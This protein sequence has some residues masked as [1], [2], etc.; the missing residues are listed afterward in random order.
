M[1]SAG[2]GRLQ[3]RSLQKH[4]ED[5]RP[6]RLGDTDDGRDHETFG[7]RIASDVMPYTLNP[8][9]HRG[10]TSMDTVFYFSLGVLFLSLQS[11]GYFYLF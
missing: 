11:R 2:A 8:Q 3:D 5:M 4:R 10:H 9:V 7:F 6:Q 1:H